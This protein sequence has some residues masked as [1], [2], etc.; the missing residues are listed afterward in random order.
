VLDFFLKASSAMLGLLNAAVGEATTTVGRRLA[1]DEARQNRVDLRSQILE[2][3]IIA[4]VTMGTTSSS[5]QQQ[6]YSALAVTGVPS[7]LSNSSQDAT[8]VFLSGL[9]VSSNSSIL[10][11]SGT[12][13]SIIGGS[14]SNLLD[15]G[16][17]AA[18]ISAT[19]GNATLSGEQ[20]RAS[21]NSATLLSTLSA[22]SASQLQ[23]VLP[24]M[25]AKTVVSKN[26]Q[27]SRPVRS[28][29]YSPPP[30]LSL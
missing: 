25:A 26:V 15:A 3:V 10:A 9:A 11:M 28:G 2:S 1:S 22:V 29:S 30:S 5:L 13:S 27:V 17:V 20:L 24:G 4:G 21:Q 12:L 19:F 8:V 18:G 14:L 23:G 7:E 6:A 16:L